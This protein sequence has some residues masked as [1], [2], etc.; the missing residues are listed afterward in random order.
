MNALFLPN[1]DEDPY[2]LLLADALES[3]GVSVSRGSPSGLAPVLSGVARNDPDVLHFHWLHQFVIGR[4]RTRSYVAATRFA[5]EVLVSKLLGISIV[6]TVRNVLQHERQFPRFE[7]RVRA[8]F[9]RLCDEIIVHSPA[10]RDRVMNAYDLPDEHDDR[11]TVVSHG[12]YVE[13]YENEVS[14]AEAREYFGFG[15]DEMVYLFFGNVRSNKNVPKLVET[16][17]TIDDEDARLAIAGNPPNDPEESAKLARGCRAD[18]RIRTDFTDIP[19]GEVQL[20]MNA[21]D[22]VVLPFTRVLTSGSVI[23]AMSFG[24]PV[25]APRLGCLPDVLGPKTELLYDPD[26]P[27]GLRVAMKRAPTLD[28][29]EIGQTRERAMSFDWDV[30][31][32]RTAAV[33]RSATDDRPVE[34]RFP[35]SDAYD[36]KVNGSAEAVTD[37]GTD[38]ASDGEATGVTAGPSANG[39]NTKEERR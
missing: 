20:Y 28:L 24:T 37:G 31:G 11:I 27:N 17:R 21:A 39:R 6:W 22:A 32:E 4:T 35:E 12:N 5:F 14:R 8:L 13:S 33:Y 7:R 9:A 36:T 2:Q 18:D 34:T 23:L 1:H 19:D 15:D 3:H 26:D 16:F 25:I 30:V 10:A 38:D 29:D